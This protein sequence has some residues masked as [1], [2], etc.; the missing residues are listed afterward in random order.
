MTSQ[1]FG[2][3]LQLKRGQEVY[4]VR[5]DQVVKMY[6]FNFTHDKCVLKL[7]AISPETASMPCFYPAE[8]V[9]LSEKDA[10]R[11]MNNALEVQ[12]KDLEQRHFALSQTLASSIMKEINQASPK[13]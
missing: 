13:P 4:V 3:P 7:Q 10:L 11:S 5:E 6:F 12:M 9:H 1:F 8:D 2:G